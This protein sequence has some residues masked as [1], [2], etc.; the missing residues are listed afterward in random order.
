MHVSNL[1]LK[2]YFLQISSLRP[3]MTMKNWQMF[4]LNVPLIFFLNQLPVKLNSVWS[5]LKNKSFFKPRPTLSVGV[6]QPLGGNVVERIQQQVGVRQTEA[7]PSTWVSI[8]MYGITAHSYVLVI[9]RAFYP[10]LLQI[11]NGRVTKDVTNSNFQ[12]I[13]PPD[14]LTKK[15]ADLKESFDFLQK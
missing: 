5:S 15:Q 7:L 10:R 6:P 12:Q 2:I 1:I 4:Q 9:Q 3:W 13:H 11:S 14:K 8:V